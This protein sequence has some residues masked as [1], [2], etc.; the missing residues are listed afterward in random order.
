VDK[1]AE[2]MRHIAPLSEKYSLVA[3]TASHAGNSNIHLNIL[4][5]D[6]SEDVGDKKPGDFQ[7]ELYAII[8]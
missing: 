1:I 2:T 5:C 7:Q 8:Y 3:R 4:R 6:L